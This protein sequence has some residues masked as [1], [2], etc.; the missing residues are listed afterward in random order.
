[1]VRKKT[2][3]LTEMSQ[4]TRAIAPDTVD[5]RISHSVSGKLA[6]TSFTATTTGKSEKSNDKIFSPTQNNSN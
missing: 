2:K 4:A 6:L 1:V 3:R 5:D